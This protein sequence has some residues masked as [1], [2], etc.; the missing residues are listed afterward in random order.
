MAKQI[1]DPT[2]LRYQIIAV[3]LP[4]RDTTSILVNNAL[5]YLARN[6]HVWMELRKIAL[7]VDPETLTFETLKSLTEFRN[8][9]WET[10]RPQGPS[11]RVVRYTKR[12]IVLPRGGGKDGQSP[13]LVKEGTSV[14]SN[15]ERFAGKRLSWEFLP[16]YAL[17]RLTRHFNCIENRDPVMEYIEVRKMTAQS[18]NG[19][20]I[21]FREQSRAA[22]VVFTAGG[23]L[24]RVIGM[25]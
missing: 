21:A 1:R 20:Q 6:L 8:V 3:F 25:K 10:M 7:S 17:V 24:P 11:G 16:F 18:R 4:A 2:E 5:S 23:E 13:I 14:D 22:S 15:P 12:D 9:L 19:V